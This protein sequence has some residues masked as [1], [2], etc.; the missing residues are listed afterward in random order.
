MTLFKLS[1]FEYPKRIQWDV[2]I[3]DIGKNGV[4]SFQVSNLLGLSW[5][6][7]QSL[8]KGSEAKHSIG[9]S[10]LTLHTRYCG[11]ELTKQRMAEPKDS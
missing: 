1:D 8:L 3:S 9:V 11:E 10:L 7:F 4:N 6:T 5:S 2:I